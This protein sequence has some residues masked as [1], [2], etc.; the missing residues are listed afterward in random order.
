MCVHFW[1]A[2][3][4]NCTRNP[5]ASYTKQQFGPRHCLLWNFCETTKKVCSQ[6]SRVCPGLSGFRRRAEVVN[7]DAFLAT[8]CHSRGKVGC[9]SALPMVQLRVMQLE[10]KR[11]MFQIHF[12]VLFPCWSYAYHKIRISILQG[13]DRGLLNSW[14]I[15][16]KFLNQETEMFSFSKLNTMKNV[17]DP[18]CDSL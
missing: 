16:K 17:I 7:R 15:I 12:P 3:I 14:P 9:K 8:A 5:Y 10:T 18:P 1:V 13:M 4:Q 11:C 6:S 2:W